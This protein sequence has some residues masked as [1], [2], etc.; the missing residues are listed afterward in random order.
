MN[1]VGVLMPTLL[2]GAWVTVKL[3]AFTLILALPLGLPFALGSNSK[4]APFRWIS[5]TYIWIFRGTPLMLQLF[6][7]YFYIPIVMDVRLDAFTTA[8][9][10]FV[11][12]YASYLAEIY[13]G[14][15]ES[16][17]KG[18]YEAAQS[19]GLDRRQTMFGIILPQTVKRVLPS[20]SNEAITL[21]KDTALVSV[22][23]VGELLKAS[24]GAVNRDV[25]AT[26]FVIAAIIYLIFT[27]LLTLLTGYLERHYSKYEG[28][29]VQITS[30]RRRSSIWKLFCK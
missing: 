7:F 19:L 27:F 30:K 20:V 15:I 22:L 13:R 11:L 21:I 26:A 5:K 9:I 4:F 23:S 3:F 1:Y 16:I 12:N 18:Q 24:R 25:N 28:H 17:D 6:F 14:G 8:V 29:E 2:Q 10:T